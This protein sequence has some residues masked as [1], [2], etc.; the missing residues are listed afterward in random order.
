MM[1]RSKRRFSK[2]AYAVGAVALGVIA[3]CG[4]TSTGGPTTANGF[5]LAT[6]TNGSGSAPTTPTGTFIYAGM[7]D[8]DHLDTASAYYTATYI[9]ERAFARQLY[10]YPAYDTAANDLNA[11]LTAAEQTV[12]DVA[13]AAPMISN[14]NKTYTITLRQGVMWNTSPPRAVTSQDFLLGFKRLCN[15]ASPIGAPQYYTATIQGFNDYCNAFSALTATD[16][17][18]FK[19]F[20]DSHNI[21][22]I[23]TPDASTIV[24]NLV[25]PAADF[26]NLLALPFASA[27]PV[28]YEQYV[29]DSSDLHSHLLSDGPYTVASYM[30]NKE[31]DLDT[32]PSWTQS[33][34]TV[35]HQYVAHVQIKE[36]L[37][38]TA[39][40]QGIET[41]AYDT[42]FDVTVPTARL[43]SLM[44]P[45]WNPLFAVFPTP[46]TN[47]YL[48]FNIKSPNNNGAL[49]NVMVRQALEYAIDKVA[50]GKIY[51]GPALNTPLDQVIPP[52]Q[53]GYQQFDPYPT[54]NH[55]GD[56][57]KCK[58]LLA[59]AG[60]ASGLTLKDVYRTSGNHP[61]VFQEVQK[62]LAACGVTVNGVVAT[63][64]G[65]YYG[66]YMD[67]Q[68]GHTSG[69]FDI[70]EPG[71]IPD[72]YGN[73][74]R[75]ILEP[76]FD[77]RTLGP[78]SVDYSYYNSDAVNALIDKAFAAT[79]QSDAANFWHQADVQI[80]MDAPFVPFQTQSTAV[81][82]SMRTHNA[83]FMPL[84]TL[85]DPTQVWLSS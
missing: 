55:Q 15:P 84:S 16:A 44:G 67:S 38:A 74:G 37:T 33:S 28:E 22:G 49:Q 46:D 75:S 48:V 2:L 3:A 4:G 73:N 7:G 69:L 78:N 23:L 29:P 70:S 20:M 77:G 19:S 79:S 36:G 25:Q 31:I 80:M 68:S 8:V 14:S 66:H 65:D 39:V 62:D 9:I 6:F 21:S 58:T 53:T 52:G 1:G 71:W 40:Q 24:F 26:V 34:D 81:M 13:T 64:G 5:Q 41:G 12:P 45:P 42:E 51:G 57:Q 27:A 18:S 54:P 30:A 76:L 35:R 63:T 60:Y 59:A 11:A 61:A 85:L 72:W 56:P 82:R 17:A 83:Q 10:S 43:S 47:P 32:N 50:M